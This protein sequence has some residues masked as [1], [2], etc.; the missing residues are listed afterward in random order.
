MRCVD[1]AIDFLFYAVIV[2]FSLELV[3]FIHRVYQSEEEIKILSEMVMNKL[4]ASLI[5]IQ[6]LLG[7]LIPLLLI[8]LTKIFKMRFSLNEDLRKMVYFIAVI[9]IQFGIFATRWNVV[10]GGQMFSKSFRGLTTYKMEFGGIEGL[11]FAILLLALPIV[12]LA[13]L[14]KILP[15]WKEMREEGTAE[16]VEVAG[17]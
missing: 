13:V 5:I 15:P 6:V 12:I 1:K 2:D 9:L 4:F 14:T 3:D 7:M 11:L 10:I 16:P 17:S 8:S